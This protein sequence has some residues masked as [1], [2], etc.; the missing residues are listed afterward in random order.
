MVGEEENNSSKTQKEKI[1]GIFE[2]LDEPRSG[3]SGTI[4]SKIERGVKK[5][6]V[7]GDKY[8]ELGRKLEMCVY[9][10]FRQNISYG[11]IIEV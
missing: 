11:F 2:A 10:S 9:L 8:P 4:P 1:W 7:R 5:C 6:I 3:R